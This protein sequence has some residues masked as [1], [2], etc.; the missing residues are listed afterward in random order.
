LRTGK[1]DSDEAIVDTDG[2]AANT[3]KF[4]TYCAKNPTIS[5]VNAAE[6]I[7]GK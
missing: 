7:L 4:G 6:E 2:F 3:K 5:I 1:G